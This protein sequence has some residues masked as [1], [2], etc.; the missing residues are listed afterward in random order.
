MRIT[1][2][3]L[4]DIHFATEKNSILEKKKNYATLFYKML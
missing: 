2:C 4:S 3:H 1:I